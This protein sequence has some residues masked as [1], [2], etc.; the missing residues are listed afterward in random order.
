[1]RIDSSKEEDNYISPCGMYAAVPYAKGQFIIIHNGQQIRCCRNLTSA[2]NF[3][4][5]ENKK[6]K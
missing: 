4:N 2:K 1:M 3:I 5:S 6:L